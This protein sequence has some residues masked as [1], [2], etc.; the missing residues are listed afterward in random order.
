[1]KKPVFKDKVK[2]YA[3]AGNGGDGMSTFRRE[4]YVPHGGPSG[5]DGA[6]GGDVVL[7]ACA[8][9]NSLLDLY[10]RPHQRAQH[11]GKGG[12]GGR[13]GRR[14]EDCEIKVPC[15]TVVF[16]DEGERIGE[17]VEDGE[18]IRVAKGGQGGFGNMHFKT[19]TNRA[20]TECTEGTPGEVM[21]LW[22]ELKIISD[23]GLV[24]Y[25]NAGKSTL[26]NRLSQ[27]HPKVAAYPF[28]TLN[29]IIGTMYCADYKNLRVADIPGLIDGAHAG[30][31]L[32]HDFLRHIERT[33][34]LVFV[35]DMGGTD[36]RNP[37]DDYLNLRKELRLY[38]AELD[39]RPYTV[40]SN[41]MDVPGSS[42]F[43]A[44]FIERAG[45][46]PFEICAEI[47]EGVDELAQS[48][49][50]AFFGPGG[51]DAEA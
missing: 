9:A 32:G 11:G 5:G 36:G 23:V 44:E 28:T 45:E 1:M 18:R 38:K 2:L 35:V 40:V 42:E 7:V 21:V 50:A 41:K 3:S 25:P 31:G 33:R 24:G 12:P 27:A 26:L 49:D 13:T 19:S 30:V 20:P 6:L 8:Q 17:I 10:Y 22:L 47:G 48:L 29:P 16:N 39:D 51:I 46:R 15:G 34:Y 37:T 14:G 43:L 4:K